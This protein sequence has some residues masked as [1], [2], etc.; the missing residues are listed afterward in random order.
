MKNS[1]L[2]H[3]IFLLMVN[4]TQVKRPERILNIFLEA[5]NSLWE[6]VTFRLLSADDQA[7]TGDIV[8]IE[9]MSKA[10]GYISIED[11]TSRLTIEEHALLRNAI[12]MIALILENRVQEKLLSDKNL[13][14][15]TLVRERTAEL[16]QANAGLKAEIAERNKTALELRRI[17]NYLK[18][19]INAMPSVLI[20][21]DREGCVTQWNAQTER[22]TGIRADEAQEQKVVDVFPELQG[23]RDKIVQSI[24]TGALQHLPK[25]SVQLNN[26]LHYLDIAIYPLIIEGIEGAVIRIDDVTSR[27]RLEERMIQ[28][29]KMR[30]LGEL[31]AGMAH[32]INNPLGIILQGIQNTQRRLSASFPKNQEIARACGTNLQAIRTYLEQ[33]HIFQYLTGIQNAGRRA[34]K[35]VTNM[36]SFSR[37]GESGMSQTDLHALLEESLELAANDYDL[38]KQYD[39]RHIDIVRQYD[40]SLP[41]VQCIATEIEQVI[42]NLFKN[43]TQAFAQN[44]SLSA[45]PQIR[46]QTKREPQAVVITVEDNGPG[47]DAD[48][49]KH[50]FEPFY[51]TKAVG[52]G[53][54]LGLAV[55]Y[56]IITTHHT[57]D[58][59]VESEVGRG[60]RFTIRLPLSQ[61]GRYAA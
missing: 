15:E 5:L 46:L 28:T 45:P 61:E 6:D 42:L 18:E 10:F 30:S 16:R 14:L 24:Q 56:F 51:T 54:G 43:S 19:I 59:A 25:V 7:E 37:P 52:A 50:I 48:I 36:L 8:A 29:E 21:V 35:I 38:K 4:L 47:M 40:P 13:Q 32:E 9:T 31:A 55:S 26:E 58:I 60:T 12:R 41:P 22:M 11:T 53:T 23:Y 39:F 2:E 1:H 57:G 3:D 34:S 33:R 17:R 44:Q 27:I 20:G 49:R